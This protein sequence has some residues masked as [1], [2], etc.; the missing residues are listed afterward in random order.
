[1]SKIKDKLLTFG[2]VGALFVG[3]VAVA[4][5]AA[6]VA[7]RCPVYSMSRSQTPIAPVHL[8]WSVV[9]RRVTLHAGCVG[10]QEVQA[11]ISAANGP[12]LG[13]PRSTFRGPWRSASQAVS[14]VSLEVHPTTMPYSDSGRTFRR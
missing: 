7:P 6:A 9:T 3:G 5:P 10:G 8:R 1:M 11:H 2:L 14:S 4:A 12:F 13:F